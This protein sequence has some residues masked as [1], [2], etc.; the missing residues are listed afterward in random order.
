L[1]WTRLNLD[2]DGPCSTCLSRLNDLKGLDEP[3]DQ[4][5]LGGLK[6]V[7]EIGGPDEPDESVGHYNPKKSNELDEPNEPG[8]PNDPDGLGGPEDLDGLGWVGPTTWTGRSRRLG[9]TAQARR[10]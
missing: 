4:T 10:P 9:R 5:G 1:I 6:D 8:R 7:N 2:L 3:D